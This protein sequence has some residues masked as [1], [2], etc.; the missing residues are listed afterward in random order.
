LKNISVVTGGASGIGA[1]VVRKLASQDNATIILDID[2]EKGAFLADELS[3]KG[4]LVSY[5]KCDVRNIDEIID[6]KT[7]I[8]NKWGVVRNLVCSAGINETL[9]AVDISLSSWNNMLHTLATGSF[10]CATEFA[11]DMIEPESGGRIVFIGSKSGLIN[12][13]TAPHCHYNIS[14]AAVIH[15]ARCLAAEWAENNILVN[16]VSPGYILTPMTEGRYE[17]QRL[18]V[19]DIPLGRMGEVRDVAGA[20]EFL[21]SDSSSFITGHNLVIDGG[22][23]LW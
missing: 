7:E 11:K 18:W 14:K 4:F 16:C 23:T 20:V 13:K 12:N 2:E 17:E 10:F 3:G 21:L 8:R 1:G 19:K 15:M 22:Y 6:S 5:I 9:K